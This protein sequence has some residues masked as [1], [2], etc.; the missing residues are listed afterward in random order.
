VDLKSF[1][2]ALPSS[3]KERTVST[4]DDALRCDALDRTGV[5]LHACV[6]KTVQR[7]LEL[8]VYANDHIRDGLRR[9]QV[10]PI[11]Q[12]ID[13]ESVDVQRC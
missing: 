3:A 10:H 12:R 8:L 6:T 5:D 7:A 1:Y 9:R 11:E 2:A 4:G 13:G